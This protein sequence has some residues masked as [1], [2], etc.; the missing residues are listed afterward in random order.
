[1]AN[2]YTEG[3][4]F[5][6]IPEDKIEAARK[7]IQRVE[8]ELEQTEDSALDL[9]WE[10]DDEG[11]WLY[12]EHSMDVDH[13][14]F[15][16]ERLQAELELEGECVMEFANTCDKPR[17]DEFGGCAF[18]AERGKPTVWLST[19]ILRDDD[20]ARMLAHPPDELYALDSREHATV[21][22]ALRLWQRHLEQG[23]I[24]YE[25]AEIAGDGELE[26]LDSDEIETLLEM[27]NQ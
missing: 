18:R 21:M 27:L 22:A 10:L 19:C 24:D 8:E 4:G 25:F 16:V 13:A 9:S 11:L 1:M 3:S 15:L 17:I 23:N 26:P 12:S 7:I 5:L 20:W 14:C 2:N 6:E